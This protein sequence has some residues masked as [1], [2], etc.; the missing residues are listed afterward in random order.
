MSLRE[1]YPDV[2]DPEK[3]FYSD[4][5]AW[6]TLNEFYSAKPKELNKYQ[7][8]LLSL[9]YKC[10]KYAEDLKP[11]PLDILE[12]ICDTDLVDADIAVYIVGTVDSHF[13][14]L[15]SDKVKRDLDNARKGK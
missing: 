14:K 4:C 11:V 13:L 6:G 12:K 8:M 1:S 15:S 9:F 10:R 2:D 5:K 7:Q 3:C